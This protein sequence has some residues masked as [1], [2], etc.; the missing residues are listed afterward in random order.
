MRSSD[1]ATAASP[2]APDTIFL[3]SPVIMRAEPEAPRYRSAE[4]PL[5][6]AIPKA[7]WCIVAP[8]WR[9]R[10]RR[11]RI[12]GRWGHRRRM[13]IVAIPGAL[14]A[15]SFNLKLAKALAALTPAGH[16][17][18]LL[19]IHG[20]PLYDGD[21]EASGMPE[22]V[23][24]FKDKIAAADGLLLVTPEYNG[25]IP[26]VTKTPSTGRRDPRR[27][28]ARLRGK[29]AGSWA[30]PRS[31]GRALDRW[32]PVYRALGVVPYLERLLCR[33]RRQGATTRAPSSTRST[34]AGKYIRASPLSYRGSP[35]PRSLMPPEL[36]GQR[37]PPRA[38]AARGARPVGPPS[39][40]PSGRG[41]ESERS[42][43]DGRRARRRGGDLA[44]P[45][46]S[47]GYRTP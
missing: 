37:L 39:A 25:S 1:A 14:R 12:R 8:A 2:R 27:H 47:G 33:Q 30:R 34:R 19:P 24:A 18:E 17:V 45:A 43:R 3:V 21:V 28:P 13:H 38:R 40:P 16:T 7:A 35:A 5:V 4:A 15:G 36:S 42:S 32:L 22:S 9:I 20:I 26:G 23:S 6:G 29:P 44:S 41:G 11:L 46:P 31:V 10:T